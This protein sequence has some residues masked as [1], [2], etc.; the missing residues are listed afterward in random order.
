MPKTK[1]AQRTKNTRRRYEAPR[2]PQTAEREKLAKFNGKVW[3]ERML[4]R[5]NRI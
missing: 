4:S 1:G 5:Q 3:N 2:Q